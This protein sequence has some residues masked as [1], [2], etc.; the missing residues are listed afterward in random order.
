MDE[1]KLFTLSKKRTIIAMHEWF[2]TWRLPPVP[3][4]RCPHCQGEELGKL[5]KQKNG[6][7]HICQECRQKFSLKDLPECR[8]TYPGALPDKC[9]DCKHYQTMMRYV[10]R[11]KLALEELNE[12]QLDEMIASPNFYD[13]NLDRRSPEEEHSPSEETFDFW[14]LANLIGEQAVQLSLFSDDDNSQ[15]PPQTR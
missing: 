3:P 1:L 12:R 14:V 6:N 7:T 2:H 10:E 9:F 11:R 15:L 13:R 4:L 5:M 8:C